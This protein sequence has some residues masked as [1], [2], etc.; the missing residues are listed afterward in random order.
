MLKWHGRRGGILGE[1]VE[2][3]LRGENTK[4]GKGEAIRGRRALVRRKSQCK[5][6]EVGMSLGFQG[7]GEKTSMIDV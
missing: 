7:M 2:R 1:K 3:P 6:P 4:D 5:G